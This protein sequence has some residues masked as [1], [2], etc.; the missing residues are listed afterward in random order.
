MILLLRLMS[1]GKAALNVDI[2][3]FTWK[4]GTLELY[5]SISLVKLFSC[6]RRVLTI[7]IHHVLNLFVFKISVSNFVNANIYHTYHL[8]FKQNFF[9]LFLFSSVLFFIQH[10]FLYKFFKAGLVC[11]T[12]LWKTIIMAAVI[13]HS[14]NMLS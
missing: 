2:F 4:L 12:F 9:F 11:V 3:I 5:F 1:S 13:Q 8:V 10:F 6:I 7:R 14:N